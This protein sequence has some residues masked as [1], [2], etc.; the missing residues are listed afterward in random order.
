MEGN[1]VLINEAMANVW[2]R[3]I[4]YMT[5]RTSYSKAHKPRT[6]N[7]LLLVV[8]WVLALFLLL[9]GK[10]PF[11]TE[12]SE[13][14]SYRGHLHHLLSSR[15]LERLI[16]SKR[17]FEKFCLMARRCSFFLSCRFVLSSFFCRKFWEDEASHPRYGHHTCCHLH[18]WEERAKALIYCC[19]TSEEPSREDQ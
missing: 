2:G 9:A 11:R 13:V 7:C 16:I 15:E 8:E 17:F 12:P 19:K 14:G 1:V 6:S 10:L 3:H 5:V 4:F 18:C